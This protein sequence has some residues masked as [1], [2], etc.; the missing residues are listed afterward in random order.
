MSAA[1]MAVNGQGRDD[2]PRRT[3]E[4]AAIAD[5]TAGGSAAKALTLIDA[6]AGARLVLGVTELAARAHL[7]K[8]TAFRLLN[9]LLDRGYVRRV[10]DRYCLSEHVFELGNNVQIGRA[11][12]LRQQATPFM[13]EL[14]AQTRQTIHLAVL[15]G[16]DVLYVEKLFGHDA[17]PRCDTAV[18][19]RK[20]AYATALGK[21]M[22]AFT[23]DDLVEQSLSTDFKRFT[24]YTIGAPA[25]LKRTIDI[26]RDTG[27]ATDHEENQLGVTC[28]AA[29]VRD[30]R[31]GIAVASLSICSPSTRELAHKFDRL[32]IKAADELARRIPP[33]DP[34][35]V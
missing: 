24:P 23:A 25:Q 4:M 8:S 16:T 11:N 14:F 26:V 35:T 19:A 15:R 7:P 32:L 5:R 3:A 21:A 1:V 17:P 12:G 22:L 27:F 28:L 2:D 20:P 13:A 30:P 6:F 34:V 29:P 33:P 9:V 10:G 18:G 31:T